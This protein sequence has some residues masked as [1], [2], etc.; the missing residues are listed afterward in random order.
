MIN[1]KDEVKLKEMGV[2]DSKLIPSGLRPHDS[3]LSRIKTNANNEKPN[4]PVTA[5]IHKATFQLN[6]LIRLAKSKGAIENPKLT[7]TFLIPVTKPRFF[8]N[9]TNNT[10]LEQLVNIP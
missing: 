2:K 4:P 6:K 5:R 1:E 10:F 8:I 9:Q 3:G 7:N